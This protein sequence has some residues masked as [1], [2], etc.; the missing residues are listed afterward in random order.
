MSGYPSSSTVFSL[1]AQAFQACL[2]VFDVPEAHQSGAVLLSSAL[3]ERDDQTITV[4]G[5]GAQEPIGVIERLASKVHLGDQTVRP[6]EHIRTANREPR[7][8]YHPP[9]C[10]SMDSSRTPH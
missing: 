2:D 3:L 10:W 9:V 1:V 5:S 8:S 6:S 7:A 4:A